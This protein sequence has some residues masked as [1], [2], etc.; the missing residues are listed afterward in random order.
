LTIRRQRLKFCTVVLL[1]PRTARVFNQEV[2]TMQA[3]PEECRPTRQ[4]KAADPKPP[5]AACE[6]ADQDTPYAVIW[7]DG[8]E[9]RLY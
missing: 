2:P 5:D 3:C 9:V 7:K 6:G 1:P 8:E 4:A